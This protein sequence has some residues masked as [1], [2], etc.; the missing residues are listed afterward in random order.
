[1][2]EDIGVFQR[3]RRG[4]RR[5]PQGDV[6]LR[7]QGRPPHRPAARGHGVGRAGVRRSTA[8]PR[9]GRSGTPRPSFRY[10]QPAGRPLPPAP[11]GR[12]RGARLGRP[13][14]RRRGHRPRLRTSTARSAC[15][16]STCV[17]NSIGTPDRPRRLRR[18]CSA[19]C[20]ARRA[21]RARADEDREKVEAH[22][23]RV[24]DSKR[25]DDPAVIADA[26]PHRS[27]TSSTERARA[28]RAGAGRARARSASRSC[29]S[30]GSS[31]GLDYYTHTTFEFAARRARRAPRP[32]SAAAAAT[33]AWSRSSAARPRPASASARASSACCSPATPRACSPAPDRR[34][35]VFV[36]D[37]TGGEPAPATSPPSCAAR[38]SAPTARF[39]GRG[40]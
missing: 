38:A 2:F 4:H 26:P 8:R 17:L 13:R 33:T 7:R 9:R 32:R 19:A 22:P 39:D 27:T 24:L 35:D 31:A 12:R 1:M 25:A 6:R 30:P 23:M 10:E 14:P 16:R 18:A 28:L 34:V 36:V 20:L 40:R 5:R 15:A 11:P 29:S 37:V 3:D 21:R